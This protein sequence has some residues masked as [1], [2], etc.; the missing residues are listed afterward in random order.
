MEFTGIA[1]HDGALMRVSLS[2]GNYF[3]WLTINYSCIRAGYITKLVFSSA[4]GFRW[5]YL[6]L[7]IL[8]VS[9]H[10]LVTHDGLCRYG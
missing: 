1:Y 6:L 10:S 3:T 2:V 4:V 5:I 8:P 7:L 9:I